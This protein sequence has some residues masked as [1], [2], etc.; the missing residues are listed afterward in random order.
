MLSN[1]SACNVPMRELI[2]PVIRSAVDQMSAS[3]SP[4]GNKERTG[5]HN[6]ALIFGIDINSA[7]VECIY[8]TVSAPMG[9][10]RCFIPK[11]YL[12]GRRTVTGFES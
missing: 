4:Q 7:V 10:I 5:P 9:S 12:S 3:G 11:R 6:L 2:R 8:G 1:G